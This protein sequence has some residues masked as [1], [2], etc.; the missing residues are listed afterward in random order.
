MKPVNLLEEADYITT[1]EDIRTLTTKTTNKSTLQKE[2]Q[3]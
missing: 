3:V 1:K 2:Q